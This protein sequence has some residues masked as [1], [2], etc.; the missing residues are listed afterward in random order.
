MNSSIDK[1]VA[2]KIWRNTF[3]TKIAIN[4]A[5]IGFE[6]EYNLNNIIVNIDKNNIKYIN[7]HSVN[8]CINQLSGI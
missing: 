7:H 1:Y 3:I 4:Q 6:T 2:S 5:K 8:C